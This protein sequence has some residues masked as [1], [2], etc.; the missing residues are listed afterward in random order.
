MNELQIVVDI[1]PSLISTNF[2]DIKSTLSEQM[3]VYK[4]LEV[5][6]EN[7]V[8]RKKDVAT[9]RKM[10]KAVNDKKVEVKNEFLKPYEA[11][12]RNVKE[13]IEIINEPIGIIDNQIKEFEEKQRLQKQDDIKAAFEAIFVNYPEL[14]E[15]DIGLVNIYDSRWENATASMKSVRDEITAK[16]DKIQN[17]VTLIKSMVSEKTEEALRLFWGDLDVTKAVTMI[18][19]YE[20]Q[21]RE[22][23]QRMIEQQRREKEAEEERQ[24]LARERELEREKQKVREE[25][26]ARIK[27]E[28]EIKEEAER[29]AR[30]NEDRFR[31]EERL[32]T[33][34]RLMEVK[35][36]ALAD[37][38][39]APF[40]ANEI[41][42]VFSITGSEEE[43]Q[44]VEMYLNS[45]GLFFMRR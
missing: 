12:E 24:R 30:E 25:E 36:S 22:I 41:T 42:A 34:K 19:R 2:E 3:Q 38:L 7:K 28:N 1:K 35:T 5:T 11:F 39:E 21:K 16:L 13:L 32:A 29:K 20:A 23:E 15:G 6:E 31:E 45:L 43:L 44:Q 17:E 4:E 14:A 27:R 9:L 33:E 37:D 8:E 40:D 18:N 10:A 26:M